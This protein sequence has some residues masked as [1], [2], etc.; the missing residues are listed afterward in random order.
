M[1][2]SY[3]DSPVVIARSNVAHRGVQL[4]S[5]IGRLPQRRL[6]RIRQRI[7]ARGAKVHHGAPLLERERA[8]HRVAAQLLHEVVLMLLHDVGVRAARAGMYPPVQAVEGA[9][10]AQLRNIAAVDAVH[11]GGDEVVANGA[12]AR[13]RREPVRNRH[14]VL[15]HLGRVALLLPV[16][17]GH[18]LE[19]GPDGR[20]QQRLRE[21]IEQVHRRHA[22]EVVWVVD[23]AGAVG[24]RV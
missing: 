23:E 20:P 3:I 1:W 16:V 5:H 10:R 11:H 19:R 14:V 7:H 6:E 21:Y 22:H 24:R 9:A 13:E 4:D 18:A 17:R 2:I 15:R 12:A 8:H